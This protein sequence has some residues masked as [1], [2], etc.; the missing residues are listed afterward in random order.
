MPK[1]PEGTVHFLDGARG[2]Y[3]P[4]NFA[5]IIIRDAVSGV[6]DEDWKIL[7]AGPDHEWYWET[8]DGVMNNA[9]ITDSDDEKYV[10]YQD[11]D[12]WL[13]PKDALWPDQ[14]FASSEDIFI[15]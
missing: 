13:I 9:V 11:S 1:F 8:W 7:E 15:P 12:L 14:D 4:Q 6:S 10:L 2:V 3:I 5:E